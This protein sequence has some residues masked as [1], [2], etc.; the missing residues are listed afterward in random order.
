M[1]AGEPWE[2]FGEGRGLFPPESDRADQ[3]FQGRIALRGELQCGV[4]GDTSV[5][6]VAE[7]SLLRSGAVE[8][9]R[10]DFQLKTAAVSGPDEDALLDALDA[11]GIFTD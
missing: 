2:R 11:A 9:V 7:A 6:R 10:L 1:F 4:G 8:A 5:Q 3:L